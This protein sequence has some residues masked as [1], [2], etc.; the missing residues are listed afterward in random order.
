MVLLSSRP[1]DF[2]PPQHLPSEICDPSHLRAQEINLL[3]GHI[4]TRQ[5]EGQVGIQF[6]G[7]DSKD[8]RTKSQ[9]KGKGKERNYREIEDTEDEA[10][11]EEQEGARKKR[12]AK[13]KS[14]SKKRV[15]EESEGEESGGGVT[16]EEDE[17]E[18]DEEEHKVV[19]KGRKGKSK[20]KKK[21][22]MEDSERGQSDG[23]VTNGD[24]EEVMAELTKMDKGKA[25]TRNIIV[26]RSGKP[27]G[28][29]PAQMESEVAPLPRSP[30][31]V[32]PSL[33]DRVTF[34]RV[35]SPHPIYL[36]CVD[37]LAAM[38]MICYLR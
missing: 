9:M 14:R 34:L 25:R 11:E 30:A 16:Y 26:G 23:G 22:V 28:E 18:E 6:I 37:D 19:R 21:R 10:D 35:L 7:A 2:F 38:V 31:A 12:K 36:A 24:E 8:T 3:W 17:V 5:K 13:S 27:P 1:A 33:E 32:G 20:A 29:A 15:I 4:L